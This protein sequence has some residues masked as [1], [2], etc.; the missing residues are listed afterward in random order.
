MRLLLQRHLAQQRLRRDGFGIEGAEER[1]GLAHLKVLEEAGGL[2]L[3]TD[4]RLDRTPVATD[5]QPIDQDGST[6]GGAYAFED[7]KSRG[8]ARAVGA[9]QAKDLAAPDGEADAIHR[10]Q[11]TVALDNVLRLNDCLA[12]LRSLRSTY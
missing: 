1:D 12:R 4:A 3:H 8:L 10:G 7:I 11:T 5:I 6:I 2:K 9:E